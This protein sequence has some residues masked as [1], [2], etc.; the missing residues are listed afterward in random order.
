MYDSGEERARA[1]SWT[2]ATAWLDAVRREAAELRLDRPALQ[3]QHLLVWR[4]AKRL[5]PMLSGV[6]N[7]NV[8]MLRIMT[9]P[10]AGVSGRYPRCLTGRVL[11][12]LRRVGGRW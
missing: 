11:R 3:W 5:I 12:L 10:V 6:A 7:A 1:P 2:D 4:D 8:R 9:S